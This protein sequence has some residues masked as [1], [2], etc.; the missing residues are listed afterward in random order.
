[1]EVYGGENVELGIRVRN[2]TNQHWWLIFKIE[3]ASY[4][5]G[6]KNSQKC[7]DYGMQRRAT[8]LQ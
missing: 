8:A 6:K 3:L 5:V 7:M 4:C 1:M 2:I